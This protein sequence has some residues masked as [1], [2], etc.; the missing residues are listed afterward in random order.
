MEGECPDEDATDE[1]EE[2]IAALHMLET[3]QRAYYR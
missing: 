2:D 3:C 1:E